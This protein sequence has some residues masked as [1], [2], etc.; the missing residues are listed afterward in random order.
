MKKLLSGLLAL[1]CFAL[2]YTTKAQTPV[3]YDQA[4]QQPYHLSVNDLKTTVLIF[5]APIAV[6]GVDRGTGDILAKT[7]AGVDNILK[8]KGAMPGFSQTNLTVVTTDGKVYAFTIDYSTTPDD[9]PIDLGKQ[10][11]QE[12][13]AALFRARKLNDE[14]VAQLA[15]VATDVKPFLRKPYDLS[16]KMKATLKG[17]YTAEDVIFYRVSFQ[18][19]SPIDYDL[20]FARFFIKDK[21]R[22]KRTAEQEKEI[23]PLFM[24]K[25]TGNSI[26]A[27]GTQTFVIAFMKFT[28]ADKK[29][30]IMQFFEQNGDRHL[31]LKIKGEDIVNARPLIAQ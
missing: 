8:L 16:F 1:L 21:R 18:N 12:A 31:Q 22:V 9:K 25:E 6:N 26:E 13:A 3:F 23:Q 30:F 4:L 7:I 24:Y 15:A 20:D 2:T 11:Q 19:R 29:N 28:I 27:G 14:Q 5:P 17:I 10:V